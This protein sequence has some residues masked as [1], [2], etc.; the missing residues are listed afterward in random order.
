MYSTRMHKHFKPVQQY[1]IIIRLLISNNKAIAISRHTNYK[2]PPLPIYPIFLTARLAALEV[3]DP[4]LLNQCYHPP[5]G[6]G[7]MI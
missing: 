1:H 2:E 6:V 5:I 4:A 7:R 3:A